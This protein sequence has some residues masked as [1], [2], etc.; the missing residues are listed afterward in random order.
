MISWNE[1]I[2]CFEQ[3]NYNTLKVVDSYEEY[4]YQ[5]TLYNNMVAEDRTV[6]YIVRSDYL[7]QVKFDNQVAVII[8]GNTNF[9]M[10]TIPDGIGNALYVIET[11]AEPRGMIQLNLKFQYQFKMGYLL[12]SIQDAIVKDLGIQAIIELI[13]QFFEEPVA[14]LDT[15]LHFIV[16]SQFR[17]PDNTKSIYPDSHEKASLDENVIMLLRKMGVLDRMINSTEPSLFKMEG[18]GACYIPIMISDIKIAYFIIYSNSPEKWKVDDYYEHFP[19]L[20]KMISIEM[21]KNNFYLLNKGNYYNYIFSMLLSEQE[22]EL[23]DIK[24]RLKVND[25]DLRENMYLI[26]IDTEMYKNVSLHKD[27]I[28]DSIRRSFRNSFYVFQEDKIYYLVSRSDNDL[29]TKQE[30]DLWEQTLKS[31]KLIAAVTGPFQSFK[32]MKQ[33]LRELELVLQAQKYKKEKGVLFLFE[34]YQAKAMLSSLR[35]REEIRIFMYQ[36]VLELAEYDHIHGS[37]LIPTLKEYLK[38]PKSISEICANLCI[39]KNTLYKRLDKIEAIMKCDYR[40]GEIIMKIELT[41]EMMEIDREA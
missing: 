22:T 35:S 32:K 13:S 19:M 6:L 21:A 20:V 1:I 17:K 38:H 41:L 31:Q 2:K 30:M 14:L 5:S 39:H 9:D 7:K 23:E 28:A 25:Y 15:S 34:Q 26:E 16:K 3:S 29:I 18:E 33:H 11:E 40:N 36:P 8:F 4:W 10:E 37:E 12:S 24:M 27:R